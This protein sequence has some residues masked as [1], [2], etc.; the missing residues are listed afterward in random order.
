VAHAVR[1]TGR[2]LGRAHHVGGE[3]DLVGGGRHGAKAE[4]GQGEYETGLHGG[5]LRM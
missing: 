4:R 3:F 2:L 1:I 5:L